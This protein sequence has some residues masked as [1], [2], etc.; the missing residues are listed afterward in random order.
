MPIPVPVRLA[1]PV[2]RRSRGRTFNEE[3]DPPIDGRIHALRLD[4]GPG[5]GGRE[6]RSGDQRS[7]KHDLV[8]KGASDVRGTARHASWK[9]PPAGAD[10]GPGPEEDAMAAP[11]NDRASR[12]LSIKNVEPAPTL[13][14]SPPVP[15]FIRMNIEPGAPW[16]R[17]TPRPAWRQTGLYPF[18]GSIPDPRCRNTSMSSDGRGAGDGDVGLTIHYRLS[19]DVAD[20]EARA[21]V[22]KLHGEAER[23][24]FKT[25]SPVRAFK[26]DAADHD[27]R[28]ERDEW[29]W[30]LIQAQHVGLDPKD[31]TIA[32][33]VPPK[34]VVGFMT[35]PGE[36]CEWASVGLCRHPQKVK[37]PEGEIS[38]GY[39]GWRWHSFC[40]TQYADE[41][42][43]SHLL[44][45]ALLDA[46]KRV[47]F[48]VKVEDP[49]GYWESRSVGV[50][51]EA[52][53]KWDRLVAAICGA[54]KD[55][56]EKKG[57]VTVAPILERPD[58]ERLEAEGVK[59]KRLGELVKLIR[60][61]GGGK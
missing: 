21:L 20:T 12:K 57:V 53:Q 13:T 36:G 4:V 51:V 33:A 40:K 37:T 54:L 35:F 10:S 25:V 23:L 42:V 52:G 44:V 61:T 3:Q 5:A 55:A 8:S 26:G 49:G 1:G 45:I 17:L 22:E 11:D 41:F 7:E 48:E 18:R 24:P 32:Y 15:M 50:L 58:F 59:D 47:G 60:A 46:A 9:R 19:S 30:F 28:A 38:T 16:F 2:T 31:R 43:R 56:G 14:P 27:K 6:E 34:R 29:L 39:S